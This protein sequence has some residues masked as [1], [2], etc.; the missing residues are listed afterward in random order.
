LTGILRGLTENQAATH[1]T[2]DDPLL[3]GRTYAIPFDEVWNAAVRI[4]KELRGWSVASAD[5]LR[6]LIIAS[7]TTRFFD[8]RD[9][10]RVWVRLDAN[11]QT[12]VDV[13][14]T[15]RT[16]RP[17]LGRN[18]RTVGHFL[19]RLD[20]SLNVRPEQILDASRDHAWVAPR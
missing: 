18:R 19:D 8:M 5:D 2:S 4:A 6:G 20:G 14:S 17:T 1:P 3:Q 11:A 16:N 15:S 9:D 10:V 7:T 13:T 12:R